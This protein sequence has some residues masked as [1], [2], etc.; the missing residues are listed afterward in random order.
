MLIGSV[1]CFVLISQDGLSLTCGIKICKAL[2]LAVRE[3]AFEA[4]IY[5]YHLGTNLFRALKAFK[6]G[7]IKNKMLQ[8]KLSRYSPFH[9]A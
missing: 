5:V 2:H 9:G 8:I 6:R 7:T 3:I 4:M 1:A